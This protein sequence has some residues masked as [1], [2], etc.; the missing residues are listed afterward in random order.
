MLLGLGSTGLVHGA[1][2]VARA[3]GVSDAVIGLT[4]VAAGT[5]SPELVTSLVAALR[6]RDDIAVGNAIGSSIFNILGILGAT[7]TVHPLPVA[8]ELVDR[9][10]WWNLA[11]CAALFPLMWTGRRLVR[12]EGAMLLLAFGTYLALLFTSA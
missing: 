1:G 5:S 3:Y 7:A 12:A 9:D 8:S 2:N 11:I 10:S 6:G 4:V